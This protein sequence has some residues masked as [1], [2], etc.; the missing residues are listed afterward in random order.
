MLVF[1][2]TRDEFLPDEDNL[3]QLNNFVKEHTVSPF[4]ANPYC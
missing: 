1:R 4:I 2:Y 3:K